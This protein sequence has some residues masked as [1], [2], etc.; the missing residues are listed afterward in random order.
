M[1]SQDECPAERLSQVLQ[2]ARGNDAAGLEALDALLG[3]YPNDGRLHFLQGSLLAGA[4][5][6]P[7]ARAAMAKAVEAAPGFALARF[8]YGL[9]ELT[10]GNAAIAQDI[11]LPLATLPAD[12]YLRTFAS[13]LNHLIRDEFAATIERLEEGIAQNTENAPLNRDMQ[14]LIDECRNKLGEQAAEPEVTS[15]AQ[16]LLNQFGKSTKH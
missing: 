10:S 13:G 6:Y 9:L 1:A 7:E 15:A 4:K 3:E 14:M 8:Q 2:V 11:L 5:R 16:L 12:H